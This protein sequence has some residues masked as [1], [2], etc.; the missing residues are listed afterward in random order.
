[1]TAKTNL[2]IDSLMPLMIIAAIT[3]LVVGIQKLIPGSS[4]GGGRG[5]FRR[6]L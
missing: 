1:M 5:Q 3:L 4:V 6:Y 2:I